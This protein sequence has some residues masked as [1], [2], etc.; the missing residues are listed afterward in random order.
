MPHLQNTSLNAVSEKKT[1]S[2]VIAGGGVA[3]LEAAMALREFAGPR[4]SVQ[5]VA[6]NAEFRYR[7]MSVREPFGYAPADQYPL[8][9]IAADIGAELIVDEFAWVDPPKQVAH[10]AKDLELPYDALLLALGA[11]MRAPFGH[12]LTLDDRRMDELLH[13]VVQDVEDGYIRSIAFVAPARMGWP[14]PLYELALMTAARAY[15]MDA[16]VDL[17]IITP[18]TAPLAIFG[19][20]ASEAVGALLSDAAITVIPSAHA[21]VPEEGQVVFH[22]G[23]TTLT[24]DRVI[25]LPELFGPSVRGLPAGEH[26]FIA[27]DGYAKVRGVER[28]YAA[29]DAVDF[30]VKHGGLAAQQADAAAESI[31]ALAG[32]PVTPQRFRGEIHGVL[33]TGREPRYLTARITGSHGFSSQITKTATWMPATKIAAQYLAPYLARRTHVPNAG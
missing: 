16:H 11:R 1:F 20:A 17:S 3:A 8:A 9:E 21:Q 32:A 12:G 28:V 14:L 26:G 23:K 5:L 10:T 27:I 7:P 29:G 18:E 25:V 24:V 33:L 2:V 6:P 30:S 4:V 31:A 19:D 13:G 15:D 22:Q